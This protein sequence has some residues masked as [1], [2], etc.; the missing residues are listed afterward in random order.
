MREYLAAAKKFK[1]VEINN[2]SKK[3]E[4]DDLLNLWQNMHG[5]QPSASL[6]FPSSS[7]KGTFWHNTLTKVKNYVNNECLITF[8]YLEEYFSIILCQK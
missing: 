7:L 1:K 4:L 3:I 5:V 8:K 6:S 2:E